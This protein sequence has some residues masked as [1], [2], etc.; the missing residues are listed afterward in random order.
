MDSM[1]A[2]A[3]HRLSTGTL[4]WML[5]FRLAIWTLYRSTL[6]IPI[7]ENSVEVQVGY[8]SLYSP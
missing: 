8:L 2:V 3:G 7:L 5:T 4:M 6:G 1:R